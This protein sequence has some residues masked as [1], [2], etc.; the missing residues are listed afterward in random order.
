ME[1]CRKVTEEDEQGE[2]YSKEMEIFN[3]CKEKIREKKL[4]MKL[5]KIEFSFDE[6]NTTLYF[7]SNGRVD[8]RELLKEL[9]QNFCV[10]VKMKQVRARDE[11][12]MMGGIGRC[13]RMLCCC[14][15]LSDFE[16]I[17]VRM[18]KDQNLAMNPSK[19]SGVCG[20]LLCCLNF[21]HEMYADLK[22]NLP[23]CGA[24]VI[25]HQGKGRI[26]KQHIMEQKLSVALEDGHEIIVDL[27]EIRDQI[28]LGQ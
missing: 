17:S 12:K 2:K 14:S 23:K 20:K 9:A 11:T 7:S 22:K 24:T 27:D 21:E 25:T 1:I 8:F 18:A 13:G 6:S 5:I 26:S 19:I 28:I 3:C 4:R 16:P 10:K 15:F